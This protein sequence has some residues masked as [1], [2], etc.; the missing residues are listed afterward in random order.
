MIILGGNMGSLTI[1]S[2]LQEP[3]AAI[4]PFSRVTWLQS[5]NYSR[6][7]HPKFKQFLQ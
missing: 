4:N 3:V 2:W 1:M 6:I 5:M 7:L